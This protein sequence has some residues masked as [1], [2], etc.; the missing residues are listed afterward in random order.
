[1]EIYLAS[2]TACGSQAFNLSAGGRQWLNVGL[3]R[4][5]QQLVLY[6]IFFLLLFAFIYNSSL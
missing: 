1:M 5:F 2:S 4:D 3:R 6:V